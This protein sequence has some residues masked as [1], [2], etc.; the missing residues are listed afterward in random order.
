M[1]DADPQPS[2]RRGALDVEPGVRRFFC[3][4]RRIPEV[5]Q[6]TR[7]AVDPLPA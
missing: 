2:A 3:R 7:G 1:D 5:S 4:P 6:T